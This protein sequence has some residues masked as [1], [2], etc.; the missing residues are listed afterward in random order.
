MR[1]AYIKKS[2]LVSSLIAV[3]LI[4]YWNYSISH[5]LHKSETSTKNSISNLNEYKQLKIDKNIKNISNDQRTDFSVQSTISQDV[6][7]KENAKKDINEVALKG[8]F[9]NTYFHKKMQSHAD[10]EAC[11]AH[12]NVISLKTLNQSLGSVEKINSESICIAVNGAIVKFTKIHG[13]ED[14]V[15]FGPVAGPN[16]KVT[17]RFCLG[18]SNYIGKCV[19]KKDEF[20][21]ALGVDEEGSKSTIG[22]DGEREGSKEDAE[23]DSEMHTLDKYKEGASPKN[24]IFDGWITES[25]VALKPLV[26]GKEDL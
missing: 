4:F 10:G 13:K 22:W 2:L 6:N 16:S 15:I 5:K 17:A 7:I 9:M 26:S 23:L 11:L 3:L 1:P 12:S 20:M 21:N 19:I 25:T 24:I 14:E 8:C 18:K